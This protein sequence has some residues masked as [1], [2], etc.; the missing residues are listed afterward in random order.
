MDLIEKILK[1]VEDLPTLPTVYSALCDVIADPQSTANDV[2]KVVSM[3]QASTIRILRIA[4]SAF[5]GFSGRIENIPRAVMIL[6]FNEVRNL[7]LASSVMNLF[8]KKKSLTGFRPRDFWA[9]SIAVGLIARSIG[10]ILGS[11]DSENFFV[12]GVLHDIG[13]LFFLEYAEK[14]F[15]KVLAS[16]AE[17]DRLIRDAEVEILG[18]D[19]ALMGSM[20]ADQWKLPG[21]I[22]NAIHY[23]HFGV[24]GEKPD[25]LVASVHVGDILARALE[26]GHPG[27]PFVPQPNES[28]WEILKLRPGTISKMVPALLRDYEEALGTILLG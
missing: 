28:I 17:N 27:D 25:L 2:A 20:L 8:S 7:I 19:H 18:L 13:K 16:V 23:H 12:A 10:R 6:G 21:P 1:N 5:Y 9:H 24:V 11:T 26:L 22:R 14:D 15:E 4:N 3:D